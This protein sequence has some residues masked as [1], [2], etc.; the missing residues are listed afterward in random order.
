MIFKVSPRSITIVMK[1]PLADQ[2]VAILSCH[3]LLSNFSTVMYL[4]KRNLLYTY[5][6]GNR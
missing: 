1:I 6:S 5:E 3:C 2:I 4:L